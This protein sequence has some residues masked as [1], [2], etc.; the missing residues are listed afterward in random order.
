MCIDYQE[1]NKKT[2]KNKYLLLMIDDLF[3]QLE[4]TTVLSLVKSKGRRC[5]EDSL[6]H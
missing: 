4:G 3:N 6:Q 5:N 1:L 2:V